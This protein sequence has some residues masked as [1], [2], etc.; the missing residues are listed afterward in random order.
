MA[1]TTL[2]TIAGNASAV[3]PASHLSASA[4]LFNHLFKTPLSFGVEPPPPP[5]PPPP[6]IVEMV[7]ERAVSIENMACSRNRA[8]MFSAKDVFLSRNFSRVCLVLTTCV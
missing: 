3:F 2:P 1:P 8:R 4:C 6:K 7:V 5:P